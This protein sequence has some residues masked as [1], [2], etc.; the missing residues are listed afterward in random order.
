MSVRRTVAGLAAGATALVLV[1]PARAA[2]AQTTL[3][4]CEVRVGGHKFENGSHVSLSSSRIATIAVTAFEERP[5]YRVQLELAGVRSTVG[6][7]RGQDFGWQRELNV[8]RYANF[9]VGTYRLHVRT[10]VDRKPCEV[11]GLIDITGRP[12]IA[13]AAGGAA[14]LVAV[15]AVSLL[16]MLLLRRGGRALNTRQ[17]FGVDDPLGEFV[18]VATPGDYVG[19]AEVA[20]DQGARTFV[21][22]KP[23]AQ[24]V[25][26]FLDTEST[27]ARLG[28]ITSRGIRIRAKD[29]GV[30]L[31]RIRWR[32]RPFVIAPLVG[33]LGALAVVLYLQQAAVLFPTVVQLAV[34]AA[35]GF[36]VG[37]IVANLGRLLGAATLNRRLVAAEAGLEVEAVEPRYPP[38]DHLDA[39]DTFV[40]TPTHTVPDEGD[41]VP[42]WEHADRTKEKVA[43]L[44]PGLPV[45]VVERR[46]GLAQVVCSNGWVGWTDAEPLEEI[47]S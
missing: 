37:M 18:T 43:T 29:G 35:I 40:W 27:H 32:P 19:W 20:C 34:A 23:N 31:P 3:G 26:A 47:T 25:R 13:T 9:G 14:A 38:I 10:I 16:A 46:D 2:S 39:L 17:A 8:K 4:E 33:I 42:A 36:V 15:V 28:E 6:T 30:A 41:G 11:T 45:R 7:G 5:R 44:D 24:E 21:T 22:T 12:P 1:M